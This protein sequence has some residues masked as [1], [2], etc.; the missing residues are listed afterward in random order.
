M[1]P[2]IAFRGTSASAVAAAKETETAVGGVIDLVRAQ[3][4]A[5][6]ESTI[7]QQEALKAQIVAY[8]EV[9]ATAESGSREQVVAAELVAKTQKELALTIG[10]THREVLAY[11]GGVRTATADTEKAGKGALA[12]SGL[13]SGM[14]RS[15]AFASNAFLGGAGLIYGIKTTVG[16]Y[17]TLALAQARGTTEFGKSEDAMKS[18]SRTA[19]TQFALSAGD[20]QKF[21]DNIGQ[22]LINMGKTPG[23]AAAISRELVTMAGRIAAIRQLDPASVM[24][25]L[26]GAVAG[27]ALGLKQLGFLIDQNAVKEEAAR[28]G[29]VKATVDT[30]KVHD[31]EVNLA[32]ARAKLVDVTSKYG[33]GTT[34]VAA[35]QEHVQKATEALTTAEAGHVATLSASQKGIATLS[36]VMQQ[37]G[38]IQ[39][40]WNDTQ[41]Q[42]AIESAKFRADLKDLEEN[43]GAALEPTV[44]SFLG[45]ADKWLSNQRN[46]HQV[47]GDVKTAVQDTTAV[48]KTAWT[49]ANHIADAVGGWKNAL[50]LLLGLKVASVVGGWTS[51]IVGSG[52]FLSAV[53]HANSATGKAGLL[54]NLEALAAIG[55]S[56]SGSRS[57]RTSSTRGSVREPVTR[58]STAS[59]P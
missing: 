19:S 58:S 54:G 33:P 45:T 4:T 23:Q 18:W 11:S 40:Q 27:R 50:L 12:A 26:T 30:N 55:R 46:L 57:S 31:A 48:V 14:G 1:S 43:I 29:I 5:T 28:L 21:S 6:V 9:A 59:P 7:K 49:W 35:A 22:L 36:L 16:A 24:D 53:T 13:F 25:K 37:H 52:G 2:T 56:P 34:Q 38:L 41:N 15:V 3:A 20:A 42:T 44:R 32:I 8:R 10:A 39:K 47:E 51:S 17:D